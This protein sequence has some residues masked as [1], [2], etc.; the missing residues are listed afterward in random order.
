MVVVPLSKETNELGGAPPAGGAST[1]NWIRIAAAS[2]LAASGA[3]L[4]T[5][6]RRAGLVTA[7]AGTALAMLDQQEIVCTWWDR[8]PGFLEEIQG[9]LNRAQLA[10]DDLSTQ[11]QKLRGVLGR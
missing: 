1:T 9:L 10:V 8:L 6:N 5:S 4:L 3:M 7:A 11:S 2:T